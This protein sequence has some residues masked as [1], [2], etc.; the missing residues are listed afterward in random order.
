MWNQGRF[1]FDNGAERRQ[2][3]GIGSDLN[4]MQPESHPNG[5]TKT[6]PMMSVCKHPQVRVIAREEEIEYV[7]CA[8]CG[9]VFD[10]QEFIDMTTNETPAADSDSDPKP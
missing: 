6:Q 1:L 8:Q 9:E 2:T 3:V 4:I 5:T 10:S 7:E